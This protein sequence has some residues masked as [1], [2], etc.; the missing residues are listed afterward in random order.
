[1]IS[2]FWGVSDICVSL[3]LWTLITEVSWSPGKRTF[4]LD[5]PLQCDFTAGQRLHSVRKKKLYYLSRRPLESRARAKSS[6]PI[7]GLETV[8]CCRASLCFQTSF[9]RFHE[10]RQDNRIW[11]LSWDVTAHI[12]NSVPHSIAQKHGLLFPTFW[13]EKVLEHDK[14]WGHLRCKRCFSSTMYEL[15]RAGTRCPALVKWQSELASNQRAPV[16]FPFCGFE[17]SKCRD[18]LLCVTTSLAQKK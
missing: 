18:L 10:E 13:W 12:Q 15:G 7:S 5:K 9:C 4:L 8:L 17:E 2:V 1:M 11:V 14:Q 3:R 16:F 6:S